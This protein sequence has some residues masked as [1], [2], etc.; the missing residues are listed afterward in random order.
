ARGSRACRR[1]SA[2]A[3]PAAW[4]RLETPPLSPTPSRR[5]CP[6]PAAVPGWA[7][8]LAG[9]PNRGSIS[10]APLARWPGCSPSPA[11]PRAPPPA[12]RS[13]AVRIALLCCDLGIPLGGVKG[14]S[15]H[16]RAVAG[17]LLRMGHQ[18]SAIVANPGPEA[19]LGT[20]VERG[21]EVRALRQPRTVREIDWHLSQVQPQLVVERLSLPAP[22]AAVAAAEG[23][24]PP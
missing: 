22:A 11:V 14:A 7:P 16:L 21:L 8:R 20:L 15:V 6:P 24:R 17:S 12:S 13:T 18:V 19:G 2:T 5:C 9:V 23:R 10:A 3:S 4:W 1:S